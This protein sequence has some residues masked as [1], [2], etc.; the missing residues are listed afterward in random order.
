MLNRQYLVK[1][2]SRVS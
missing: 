2:R 1:T